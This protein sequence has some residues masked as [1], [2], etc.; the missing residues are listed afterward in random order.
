MAPP[1]TGRAATVGAVTE[2]GPLA[3]RVLGYQETMKRLVPSIRTPQDWAELESFVAVDEFERIGTFMEV[4]NWQQ[5]T[6]LLA[7]WGTGID[8]FETTVQRVS[9]LPDLVYFAAEERH[10][11]GER[12]TVVNSLSMFE[13][14]ADAKIRRL[15]VYMQQAR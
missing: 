8:R 13:F 1:Q 2:H 5:Y 6:Q 10:F 11:A 12:I 3:R 4:Q 15:S 14:N 9:E 7:R